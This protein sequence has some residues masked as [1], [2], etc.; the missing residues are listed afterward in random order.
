MNV[1]NTDKSRLSPQEL[2][3]SSNTI[4][5]QKYRKEFTLEFSRDRK[6]MSSYVI[7]AGKG[8]NSG[9]QT[10]K[11]FVKGA[12]ESIVERSTHIRVGTQKLPM[13]A[14]I[15]HEIMKLV[16]QYGTGRDTLRCLAL[17]T[18]DNPPKREDMDLEDSRKFVTYEVKCFLS[19]RI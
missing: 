9:Q 2:A 4:I 19:V 3:M 1:F 18:I 10:A 12:P 13:T 8:A 14:P 5:R 7:A 11:M 17:G 6:S 15:K 16:Q